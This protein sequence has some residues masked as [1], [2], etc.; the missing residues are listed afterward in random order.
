MA[1][2][3][4]IVESCVES[5]LESWLI[6][7]FHVTSSPPRWWT[8]NKRSLIRS[9]C[10]STSICSFP[11]FYLC[12]PRPHENHLQASSTKTAKKVG[13]S[14]IISQKKK[15]TTF[16]VQHTCFVHFFAVVLHGYNV[17]L[18]ETSQLLIL[19]RTCCMCS[20]SL[21]FSATHFH[22]GGRQHFS[23]SHRRYKIFMLLF[24][25]N[26]KWVKEIFQ[27]ADGQV[28]EQNNV[29]LKG[30]AGILGLG[31]NSEALRPWIVAGPEVAGCLGNF[32]DD[33]CS[34]LHKRKEQGKHHDQ[35]YSKQKAL[36]NDATEESC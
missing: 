23:F 12:L 3:R 14:V 34:V 10:L 26:K 31:E 24:Q 4:K 28:H 36:Q 19:R 21:F 35:D 8:V 2:K 25:R 22:L 15:P 1:E 32:E 7:G 17:K 30:F 9:F 13:R 6:G 18:P 11:H 27:H 29:I 20:C 16:H 33:L 5:W